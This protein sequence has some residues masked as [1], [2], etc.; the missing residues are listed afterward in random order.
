MLGNIL[1]EIKQN[2]KIAETDL[3][4]IDPRAYPYKKGQVN[5]AK[6]KLEDLYLRY[7]NEIMKRS[8]FILTTGE[9]SRTFAELS[10]GFSCFTVNADDFYTDIASK[11]STDVYMKKNVN[12][13]V[14][15][16]LN[17]LIEDKM[18]E[19]DIISYNQLFFSSKYQRMCNSKADFLDVVKRSITDNVGGE[20]VGLDALEKVCVEAVNKDYKSRLVPIVLHSKDEQ[21][22]KQLSSD[23]IKVNPRVVLVT[24]GKTKLKDK[25]IIKVKETT[26]ESVGKALK[27]IAG[28]A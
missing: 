18:K 5:S 23:I 17:N 9:E 26:E 21:L 6:N 14:F 20:V 7:K 28:N 27:K 1:E 11:V 22:I 13:S 3:S 15:D 12:A 19:L 24:S 16:I 2:K 25:N 8:V 4:K 10:E